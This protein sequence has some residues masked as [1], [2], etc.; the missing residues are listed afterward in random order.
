MYNCLESEGNKMNQHVAKFEREL[1]KWP[2]RRE[3]IV[4]R[5]RWHYCS[6]VLSRRFGESMEQFDLDNPEVPEF[7]AWLKTKAFVLESELSSAEMAK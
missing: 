4:E 2:E 5:A 6:L 3:R 7:L 1:E